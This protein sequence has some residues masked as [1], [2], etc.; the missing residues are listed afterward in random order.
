MSLSS[1]SL[2]TLAVVTFFMCTGIGTLMQAL[3]LKRRTESWRKAELERAAVCD[4]L[5]SV[6]ELWSFFA[7]YLFALSGL[8]RS[9]VDLFLVGSRVPV[10]ALSTIILGYLAYHSVPRAK[11]IFRIALVSDFLLS[12]LILATTAGYSCNY[13]PLKVLC[14]IAVGIVAILLFY[15]KQRQAYTMYL[16]SKSRAVSWF[17]EG[18]IVLKDITGFCYAVSVG[19]ELRWVAFTHILSGIASGTIFLVKYLVENT[20]KRSSHAVGN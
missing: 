15:G 3:K 7:Y 20:T 9:Q 5:L 6:R 2:G 4:G 11:T 17:R 14:D 8:T 13:P 19:A 18:G 10:V 1:F 12:L 16:D